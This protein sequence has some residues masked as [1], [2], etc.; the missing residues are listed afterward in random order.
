MHEHNGILVRTRKR[1]WDRNY[2]DQVF[3]A[4]SV[5][6]RDDGRLM[7]YL[8][9]RIGGGFMWAEETEVRLMKPAGFAG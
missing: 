4:T 1:G 2:R 3:L 6:V 9:D 5:F 8:Q 7:Y